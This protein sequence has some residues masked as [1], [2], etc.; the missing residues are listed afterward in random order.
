MS[1]FKVIQGQIQC[2]RKE[3]ARV[4]KRNTHVKESTP[5]TTGTPPQA[6]DVPPHIP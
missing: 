1:A 3:R 6:R 5:L 2:V 4:K